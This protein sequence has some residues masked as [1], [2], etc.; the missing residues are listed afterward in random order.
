MPDNWHIVD[1]ICMH[2]HV[3]FL[4][5]YNICVVLQI[6]QCR[7]CITDNNIHIRYKA[8]M[9]ENRHMLMQ[10]IHAPF[11]VYLEII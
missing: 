9:K 11:Q 2:L 7:Y 4:S 8:E 5:L 6:D 3:A 1:V 10:Y